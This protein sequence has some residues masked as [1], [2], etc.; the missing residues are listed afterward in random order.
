[1][2]SLWYISDYKTGL[3]TSRV[4]MQYYAIRIIQKMDKR[5]ENRK[6]QENKCF[7]FP[8]FTFCD[9]FLFSMFYR[10]SKSFTATAPLTSVLGQIAEGTTTTN[11]EGNWLRSMNPS[12]T[13]AR[14][15]NNDY[16]KRTRWQK[17][18]ARL[19]QLRA[20]VRVVTQDNRT[21]REGGPEERK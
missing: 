12:E 14:R 13:V 7:L 3:K 9:I 20:T 4:P 15:C 6:Q 11:E 21:D 19:R 1:M 17:M 2:L 5:E 18:P 10:R 8:P 16:V